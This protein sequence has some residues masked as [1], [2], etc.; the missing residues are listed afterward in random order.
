LFDKE[1]I[2]NRRA[3]YFKDTLNKEYLSCNDQGKSVLAL[4]IEESDKGENVEM[5]TYEETEVLQN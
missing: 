1:E 5:P 2:M 4:N 3:E